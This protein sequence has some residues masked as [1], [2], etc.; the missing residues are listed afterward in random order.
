MTKPKTIIKK[1]SLC[2]TEDLRELVKVM[3]QE[4]IFNLKVGEVEIQL[5]QLAF[6]PE[7]Q[8][9]DI[10]KESEED[11]KIKELLESSKTSIADINETAEEFEISTSTPTKDPICGAYTEEELFRT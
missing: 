4:K 2:N 7:S 1:N 5:S 9:V 10:T 11:K 3:K 8:V 6:V